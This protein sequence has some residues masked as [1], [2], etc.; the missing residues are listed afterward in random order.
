MPPTARRGAGGRRAAGRNIN[1]D[2]EDLKDNVQNTQAQAQ[3]EDE[4][5]TPQ[6]TAEEIAK[7]ANTLAAADATELANK[8]LSANAA[9][10][11]VPSP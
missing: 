2:A 8:V 3:A 4:D 7:F 1:A 5:D 9:T 10:A 11:V 6:A